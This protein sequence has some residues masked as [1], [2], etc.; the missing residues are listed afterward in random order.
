MIVNLNN[1]RLE[2]EISKEAIKSDFCNRP[3]WATAFRNLAAE[4]AKR[5]EVEYLCAKQN[6]QALK[7]K[8]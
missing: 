4:V 1:H 6:K 5:D 3:E 7:S 2:E 8:L